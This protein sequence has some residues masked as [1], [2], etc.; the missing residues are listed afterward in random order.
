MGNLEKSSLTKKLGAEFVGT[1]ILIFGATAAPI[2]NQKYYSG[3]VV[4]ST[5][6]GNAVCAG[7]AV[8]IVVI[9]T[10]HISGAHLNP[11]ITIAFATLRK[12]PWVQVPAYIAV[13]VIASISASYVLKLVYHP[14]LSGG[15]TVPNVSIPQAFFIEFIITFNLLF[16]VTAVATDTETIGNL[17]GI[18]I[19]ATVMLNIFIAGPGTGGSM[20]PVRTL[21]P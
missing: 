6:I 18:A 1:F 20:N 12:F 4:E 13:Q 16:V 11:S 7:L 14:F 5:L 9:S 17:G 19:G 21:G 3:S 8:M 15:L 2:V 10:G